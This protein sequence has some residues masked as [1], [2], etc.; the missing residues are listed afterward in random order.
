LLDVLREIAEGFL[1]EVHVPSRKE[2]VVVPPQ[3]RARMEAF[4]L[5]K[6][7]G[8]YQQ[9]GNAALE[10]GMLHME[11]E[12][13][14]E[15]E[16]YLNESNS[17]FEKAG[18]I[19]YQ[20]DTFS[21]L[22]RLHLEKGEVDKATALIEKIYEY[23]TKIKNRMAICDAEL[24]KA[25]LCRKQ[26]NWK[27]SIQHFEKSLQEA[28]SLSAQKWHVFQYAEIYTNTPN[29]SGTKRGRR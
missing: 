4:D 17:I 11:M 2:S 24:L 14:D 5:G 3:R 23:T 1:R 19:D 15:A 13:H 16:K 21:A 20:T 10:L 8:E 6:A 7:V 25:M 26:K 12:D 22:S 28:K 27:Q 18:D 9:T 29:V